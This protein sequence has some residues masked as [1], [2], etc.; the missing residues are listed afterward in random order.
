[1]TG[2]ETRDKGLA[3][4]DPALERTDLLLKG[5]AGSPRTPPN[6][7]LSTDSFVTIWRPRLPLTFTFAFPSS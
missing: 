5:S 2:E 1:M 3:D 6:F 4:N 7:T